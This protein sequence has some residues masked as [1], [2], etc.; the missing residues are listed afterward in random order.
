M[1]WTRDRTGSVGENKKTIGKADFIFHQGSFSLIAGL[2]SRLSSKC[3]LI[4]KYRAFL[5]F[6]LFI[7]LNFDC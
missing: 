1:Q 2:S 6:Y 7:F 3:R 4:C 5:F